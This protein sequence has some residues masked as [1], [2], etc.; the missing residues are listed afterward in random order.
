MEKGC[1]YWGISEADGRWVRMDGLSGGLFSRDAQGLHLFM[2]VTA[3]HANLF[4][5]F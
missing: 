2:Q 5:G 4:G 1:K 3:L